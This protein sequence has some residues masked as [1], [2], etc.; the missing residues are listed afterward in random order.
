VDLDEILV[1]GGGL[2]LLWPGSVQVIEVPSGHGDPPC[3]GIS[4]PELLVPRQ[5]PSGDLDE[6]KG[7]RPSK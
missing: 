3:R 7:F 2:D 5:A 1:P 4:K 6:I